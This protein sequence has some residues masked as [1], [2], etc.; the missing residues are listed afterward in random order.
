[1]ISDVKISGSIFCFCVHLLFLCQSLVTQ[2]IMTL[3]YYIGNLDFIHVIY[4]Y[5]LRF[6]EK[7]RC[8]S[9]DRDV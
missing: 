8:I 5:S 3:S 7:V 4:H 1:M 2:V 6:M 9:C